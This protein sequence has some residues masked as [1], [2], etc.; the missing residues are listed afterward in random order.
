[1]DLLTDKNQSLKQAIRI[2][3][4]CE[5][6]REEKQQRIEEMTEIKPNVE[7][8]RELIALIGAEAVSA[9]LES[10]E[11]IITSSALL[12]RPQVV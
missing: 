4:S 6:C 11:N 5:V 3:D 7:A 1:M 8:Y 12:E 2:S 9:L 10:W